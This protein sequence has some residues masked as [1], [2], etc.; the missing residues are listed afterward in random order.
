MT[1][2]VYRRGSIFWA[3][4][5]ITVGVLFLYQNFNPAIHPWQMEA[6]LTR[7]AFRA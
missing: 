1:A 5:L 2:Y 6:R 3:L 4:T 7:P